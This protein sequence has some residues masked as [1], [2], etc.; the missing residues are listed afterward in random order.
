M[1]R[2]ATVALHLGPSGWD[3]RRTSGAA[4][5]GVRRVQQSQ[6]E[7]EIFPAF[8]VEKTGEG[9]KMVVFCCSSI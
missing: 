9:L 8:S 4:A 7:E 2:S 1:V 5:R 6:Q 3:T